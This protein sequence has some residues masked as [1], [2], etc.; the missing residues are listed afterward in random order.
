MLR[1]TVRAA[2]SFTA[3]VAG[4]R[5]AALG[6]YAHQ[7]VPFE[8]LVDDLRPER[9]LARHPLFQVMLAFQNTPRPR[10][11]LPGTTVSQLPA[12]TAAT[13]FDLEFSW[14]ETRSGDGSP[15]GIDGS[16][17]YRTDLFDRATVETIAAR[18]VRVL[19]QVAADPGLRVHQITVVSDAERRELLARNAT[20]VPVPEGTVA[21]LFAAWAA[22]TPDA[23]AV[24]DGD[25]VLSY[26]FLAGAAARLG[27]YLTGRGAGPESVV[28]VM[29]PRSAQMMIAVLGVAWAGAAYL[30]VDPGYPAGRAGFMLADA[31]AVAVVCTTA[32]AGALPPGLA[33]VVLDD[34]G[35][36]AGLA[37][38][39][40][41]GPAPVAASGAVYVMY[42]SGST[43][44]PKGVVVTH[45]GLVNRLWWMQQRYQ[46]A[47]GQR[48][49]HKTPAEL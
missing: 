16:V 6:A 13:R 48:V 8:H 26:G 49:V 45:G 17:V 47:A 1:T 31:G 38:C 40:A 39:P 30:P 29:V 46:L 41:G 10:L 43:G 23:V 44:V 21:G 34:P 32:T 37:R 35:V 33:A 24:V 5:Q 14:R 11:D 15:A 27:S 25:G 42:T 2:D 9:S 36:R 4:A 12:A 18:L 19:E 22:R 20:G 28:A 7:D 3:L